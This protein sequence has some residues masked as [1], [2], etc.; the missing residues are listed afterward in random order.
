LGRKFE[1]IR[2]AV[3]AERVGDSYRSLKSV[4]S[5]PVGNDFWKM[6]FVMLCIDK[7]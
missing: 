4:F 7:S 5:L 2:N 1:A 3:S 6:R